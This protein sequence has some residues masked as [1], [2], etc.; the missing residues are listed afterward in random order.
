MKEKDMIIFIPHA[1]TN[2]T[3]FWFLRFVKFPCLSV[4]LNLLVNQRRF[5]EQFFGLGCHLI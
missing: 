5:L 1:H 3:K 2:S 4:S